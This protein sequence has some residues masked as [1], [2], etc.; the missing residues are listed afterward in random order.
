M[1]CSLRRNVLSALCCWACVIGIAAAAEVVPLPGTQPLTLEGDITSQ[2]VDGVDKFLLA[3]T[4]Q[5][6]RPPRGVLEARISSSP[7]GV[8]HIGR[9]E[10]P[11][12]GPHPRRARPPRGVRRAGVGGHHTAAGAGRPRGRAT[13][14]SR[15]A[16]RPSAT[17]MAK[18][19]CWYRMVSNLWP[20]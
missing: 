4:G 16:G 2:L 13:R 1:S 10:P 6:G 19:C 9:A 8:R 5:V 7:E 20:M 17:Y 3:E 12:A 18:A 14:S 11:A 15:S